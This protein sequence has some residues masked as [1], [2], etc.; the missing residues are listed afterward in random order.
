MLDYVQFTSLWWVIRLYNIVIS[1]TFITRRVV[2][3]ISGNLYKVDVL[4]LRLHIHDSHASHVLHRSKI[5]FEVPL[6]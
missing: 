3:I 2:P 6:S 4:I 1:V 5:K